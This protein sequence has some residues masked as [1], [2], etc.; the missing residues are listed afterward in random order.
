MRSTLHSPTMKAEIFIAPAAGYSERV[1]PNLHPTFDFLDRERVVAEIAT[2]I[3]PKLYLVPTRDWLEGEELDDE[4]GYTA[5]PSP[6]SLL[7]DIDTWVSSFVLGIIE[8]WS[9]KRSPAQLSRWTHRRVFNALKEGKVNRDIP[10][11]RKIHIQAPIE[12][13]AEVTVTLRFGERIKSLALR[14]EGVDQRW[15]CTELNLL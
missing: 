2:T 14:F 1:L 9:G 11:I 5:T 13:V 12:G 3:T 6:I 7:P 15:L 8:I 4:D 10:K